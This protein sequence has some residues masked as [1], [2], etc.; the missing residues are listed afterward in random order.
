MAENPGFQSDT[1][2]SQ[3]GDG[4][5]LLQQIIALITKAVGPGAGGIASQ[6]LGP[7]INNMVNGNVS[8]PGLNILGGPPGINPGI[9]AYHSL[10][11]ASMGASMSSINASVNEALRQQNQGFH[12]WLGDTKGE[13][14]SNSAGFNVTNLL[15]KAQFQSHNPLA[16][17]QGME[18]TQRY[19]GFGSAVGL[20]SNGANYQAT[21]NARAKG[22]TNA[23]TKDFFANMDD[24]SGLGG[25]EIGQITSELAR[26]GG[27]SD[28][29]DKDFSQATKAVKDMSKTVRQL[30]DFFKGGVADLIDQ[31]NGLSGTDF[32]ATF[33][34][35]GS[36]M[37]SMSQGVGFA[38]GHTNEQMMR[39]AGMS[40][41]ASLSMGGDS[42]GAIATSQDIATALGASRNTGSAADRKFTNEIQR[43][44]GITSTIT[45][46]QQGNVARDLSGAYAL[47]KGE[48]KSAD[49][50]AS[51]MDSLSGKGVKL[52]GST[53]AD[54]INDQFGL[55]ASASEISNLANDNTAMEYRSSGKA[56]G[57]AL[58]SDLALVQAQRKDMLGR[59]LEQRG[60]GDKINDIKG[61]ITGS[62]IRAALG[63]GRDANEIMGAFRSLD[64]ANSKVLLGMGSRDADL[65]I[66][67]QRNRD[68][69]TRISSQAGLRV[70]LGE[71]Y[72]GVGTLSGFRNLSKLATEDVS[73]FDKFMKTALGTT[74]VDLTDGLLTGV[75]DFLGKKRGGKD[76]KSKL[77]AAREYLGASAAMKDLLSGSPED[78]KK[79]AELMDKG[80][81]REPAKWGRL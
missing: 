75:K 44:S 50:I 39:L 68:E 79:A 29:R 49:D 81:G 62:S 78:V 25:D 53:I 2:F 45:R 4:N 8:A 51:F 34:K 77:Q 55:D 40:R 17:M 36:R 47:L 54:A 41:Q 23:I 72:E 76:R 15:S 67:G 14:K 31:V 74:D 12:E 7:S 20:S 16:F 80:T 30:K 21:V 10:N 5:A 22:V 60:M 37:L 35:A 57:L 9:S 33:G 32:Q 65:F 66:S 24:Y 56:T 42:F 6:F 3:G 59:L 43:R 70:D 73:T 26:S 58:K 1:A 69:L 63:T 19:M 13:A 18:E 71:M 38:T 61:P 64:D 48:G 28:Q 46:S 27:L 52:N 11:N